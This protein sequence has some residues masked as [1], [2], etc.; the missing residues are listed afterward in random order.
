MRTH[1]LLHKSGHCGVTREA[2]NS[3]FWK[4]PLVEA[5]LLEVGGY[6]TIFDNCCHGGVRKKPPFGG[7]M[8]IGLE[9]LLHNAMIRITSA[10]YQAVILALALDTHMH[11]FL[12]SAV[13]CLPPLL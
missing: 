12:A 3:L 1:L 7:P 8:W 6:N 13:L 10:R 5:F 2:K 9:V 11:S 4:I